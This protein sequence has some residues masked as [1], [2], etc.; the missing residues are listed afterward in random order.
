MSKAP[1]TRA[2]S[3]VPGSL[4]WDEESRTIEIV[5][6][7]GVRVERDTYVEELVVSEDS[8]DATRLDAGAVALIWDHAPWGAPLGRV[9]SHRVEGGNAI[10][11][12]RLSDDPANAGF[13]A[14][15]R[16]G[17][18][19]SVSVGYAHKAF[20]DVEEDGVRVRRVTRWEPWEIS[21][22][23]VP[24]DAAAHIRSASGAP[25]TRT[26][27]N[28]MTGGKK[29][30]APAVKTRA[31]EV[32]AATEEAATAV[33]TA[34]EAVAE[35]SDQLAEA[36]AAADE[37]AAV[38]AGEEVEN[39]EDDEEDAAPADA[40]VAERSRISSILDYARRA[41]LSD[42]IVTR[43]I[44]EGRSAEEVRNMTVENRAAAS[45]APVNTARSRIIR[46]ERET[47]TRQASEVIYG[48][49]ASRTP[50]AEAGDLR[51]RSLVDVAGRFVGMDA[52][53]HDP[54]RVIRSALAPHT[55][56]GMHSTSDFSF[57]GAISTAT[58]RRVREIAAET[59]RTYEPFVHETTTRDFRPIETISVSSFPG[60]LPVAEGAPAKFG[61]FSSEGGMFAIEEFA[62]AISRGSNTGTCKRGSR[63]S[64][65]VLSIGGRT[66][67]RRSLAR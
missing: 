60:L 55:R 42:E 36:Q 62:R 43:H 66:R 13:I 27:V 50:S 46:D 15:I 35:A 14:D 45:A 28:A 41:R 54:S 31:S 25:L 18:I 29:T 38:A 26:E 58:E 10:A 32:E 7:T 9:I 17:V 20:E 21:I 59:Q 11:V 40:I 48:R 61:T 16:A 2:S 34:A 65:T 67:R 23:T 47:L 57:A 8:I 56:T 39:D 63:S 22:V 3:P 12:V 4:S 64:I 30:T 49:I 6:S 5:Y 33:E 37:A 52:G 24:A 44:N 1:H 51:Y 53:G 19:R